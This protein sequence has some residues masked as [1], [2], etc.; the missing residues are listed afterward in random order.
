MKFP[1]ILKIARMSVARQA[2]TR[3]TV[4]NDS[5]RMTEK[6]IAGIE[7]KGDVPTEAIRDMLQRK[8]QE[9]FGSR[10]VVRVREATPAEEAAAL[11]KKPHMH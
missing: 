6:A 4:M 3:H 10:G 8:L 7:A 9:A 11:I 5:I 1:T 2:M